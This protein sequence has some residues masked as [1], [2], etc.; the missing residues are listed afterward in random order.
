M[1]S[2]WINRNPAR[3]VRLRSGRS[4]AAHQK[5]PVWRRRCRSLHRPQCAIP[6]PLSSRL[7]ANSRRCRS[8]VNGFAIVCDI[9]RHLLQAQHQILDPVQH[10][11]Q[12]AARW[13]NSSSVPR[14][15]IRWARSPAMIARACPTDHFD[16]AQ[17]AVARGEAARDGQHDSRA[18]PE[19]KVRRMTSRTSSS[20]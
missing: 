11:V 2:R 13:S 14:S 20:W 15:V 19:Q 7:R 9:A 8:R 10:R 12:A 16:P 18:Q 1:L 4:A 17:H 5:F 3:R 6:R